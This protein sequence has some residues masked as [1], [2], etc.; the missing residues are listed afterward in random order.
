M[1]MKRFN[2][3]VPDPRSPFSL[4]RLFGIQST[5]SLSDSSPLIYATYQAYLRRTPEHLRTSI[6]DAEEHSYALGVKLVRGAY[7]PHELQYYANTTRIQ[8]P[9]PPVWT[10][11]PETDACY[12][13]CIS[14]LVSSVQ[15]AITFKGP[16]IG[17]LFGTHNRASV[18]TILAELQKSRLVEVTSDRTGDGDP[19]LLMNR[20][21][22]DR[23]AIG[24]LFGM[25]DE[26]TNYIAS[27]VMCPSPFVIKYVP[28]GALS[29]VMPYLSRRAIENTS[30]LGGTNG[31]LEERKVAGHALWQRIWGGTT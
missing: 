2:K 9:M 12:D 18:Q 16:D 19:A 29:E 28:Y 1:L 24:Q 13:E 7:H 11:K 20:E 22:V 27:H 8:Q 3:R 17:V 23:V 25:S 10:E 6:K 5:Y 15:R 14:L 31:A 26:L 4:W 21:V 30:V